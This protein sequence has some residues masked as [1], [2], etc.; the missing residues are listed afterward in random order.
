[1]K[2]GLLWR[3]ACYEGWSVM[4]GGLLSN[5]VCFNVVRYEKVCDERGLLWTWFDMNVVS[6]ERAL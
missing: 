2:G 5:V 3:V 6:Y 1:M 4:K